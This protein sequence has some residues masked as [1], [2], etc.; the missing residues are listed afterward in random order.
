M[1]YSKQI[2][3]CMLAV[4]LL[5]ACSA[6]TTKNVENNT[7]NPIEKHEQTDQGKAQEETNGETTNTETG[8]TEDEQVAADDPSTD[9]TANSNDNSQ[10]EMKENNQSDVIASIKKQ[11]KTTLPVSL[12][13]QLPLKGGKYLTATTKI[14]KNKYTI[15]FYESNKE[16]PINDS[17]LKKAPKKSIIAKYKVVKYSSLEKA[18]EEISFE[19]FS[20][21]GGQ[22]M[23]LGHNI[24]GYQDAGAGA[25]WTSWNEGRWAIATHTRTT[26]PELGLE[27]AKQAVDYLEKNTLPI[28]K[29]N[30]SIRLD[31]IKSTENNVKWQNKNIV[32][33]IEKVKDPIDALKTA[34]SIE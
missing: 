27:L 1:K 23:N 8:Q 24:I 3:S 28:P 6:N 18:N 4:G 32:Y 33:S 25:L 15:V 34:T 11:L 13:N 16:V 10:T 20:K 19:D 31:A 12:P 14:E 2:V 17:S 30:G 22:K 9:Q 7:D 5:S 29:P 26:K 21:V